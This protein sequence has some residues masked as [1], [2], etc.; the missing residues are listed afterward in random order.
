M[1]AK[2]KCDKMNIPVD[3]KT[4][5][6]QSDPYVVL[7]FAVAKNIYYLHWYSDFETLCPTMAIWNGFLSIDLP[8]IIKF[9]QSQNSTTST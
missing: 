4:Y 7:C 8:F 2:A 9:I 1:P 6:S 3:R 5:D